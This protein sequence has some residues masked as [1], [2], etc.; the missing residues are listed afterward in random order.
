[1]MVK[2]LREIIFENYYYEH[3]EL[4]SKNKNKQIHKALTINRQH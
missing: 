3:Y 2:V 4:F 1:M